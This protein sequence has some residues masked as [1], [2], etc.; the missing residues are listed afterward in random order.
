MSAK[1]KLKYMLANDHTNVT[2]SSLA[3]DPDED[4]LCLLL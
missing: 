1:T 2:L 3:Y 4:N